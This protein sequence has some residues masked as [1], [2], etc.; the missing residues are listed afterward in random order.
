MKRS[1]SMILAIV[2]VLV[3]YGCRNNPASTESTTAPMNETTG[4]VPDATEALTPPITPEQRP[5]V[6][7]S[8]PVVTETTTSGETVIFKNVYQN[9]ELVLPEPEVAEKVILD[10]L[11]RTDTSDAA[12]SIQS[13]AEAAYASAAQYWTPYLCQIT[14][15]P[16][17]IDHGVLSLYGSYAT[18]NG[19]AHAGATHRAVTYDLLTGEVLTLSDVL[20]DTSGDDLIPLIL[21]SLN[22]QKE[23]EQLYEGFES[24]VNERFS[25]DLSHENDWFFSDT[26]LCFF[27]SAYEIGPY[28]SDDV[29]ATIA[30]EDLVG[31]VN[32]AYF[33]AE[34]DTAYGTID[35][36]IFS[37]QAATEFTQFAD[38]VSDTDGEK[39]L[40]HTDL[41]VQKVRIESGSWSADGSVFTPANTIFSTYALTPGDA[42]LLQCTADTLPTL[43]LSYIS[44][45]QLQQFYISLNPQSNSV[46]L[47]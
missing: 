30:Y 32:D 10:F 25:K 26:G 24:T 39:I 11:N 8:L 43:R 46:T 29:V 9:I 14:Y 1:L 3:M 42:V 18:Y 41:S 2:M 22:T 12:V 27:F 31:K 21:D 7:I 19:A 20:T 35:A 17:R 44:N 15:D 5:M 16:M 40:L 37:T 33:P 23:E 28:A 6:A 36:E 4:T 47:S 38:V 34:L 45:N 13:Q